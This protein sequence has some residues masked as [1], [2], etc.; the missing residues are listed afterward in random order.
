MT[1]AAAPK[2]AD[3]E[4]RKPEFPATVHAYTDALQLLRDTPGL[5]AD[6]ISDQTGRL[7]WNVKRDLHKLV[8]AGVIEGKGGDHGDKAWSLT[9]KGTRW[10]E[11]ID[12]ASGRAAAATGT[13][14]V[15]EVLLAQLAPDPDQPRKAFDE[16]QL[17]ELA[18]SIA[19]MGLLQPILVRPA[20]PAPGQHTIIAGERRYRAI[21]LLASA[22]RWSADTPVPIR[23]ATPEDEA[24]V[25]E[26]ALVENT[27]R[28]DLNHMEL[29]LGYQRLADLGRTPKQ[30]AAVVGR[31]NDHVTQHLRL[32]RLEAE[33]QAAVAAGTLPL[34]QALEKLRAPKDTPPSLDGRGAGGEGDEPTLADL[35]KPGMVVRTSYNTGPYLVDSVTPHTDDA[36]RAWAIGGRQIENGRP[37]GKSP[38]SWLNGYRLVWDG[39]TPRFL[40]ASG[41]E[42]FIVETS[43]A[44]PVLSDSDP[45]V[46]NGIRYPNTTRA[47]EA[48]YAARLE[49]RKANHSAQAASDRVASDSGKQADPDEPPLP[50]GTEEEASV[51]D[52]PLTTHD[53]LPTLSPRA[54][55]ALIELAHKSGDERRPFEDGWHGAS[56]GS[57]WLDTT[58]SELTAAGL[59]T[60]AQVRGG[61]PPI[62]AL[63]HKGSAWLDSQGFELPVTDAAKEKAQ[64]A[65]GLD[66]HDWPYVTPWLAQVAQPAEAPIDSAQ[67][68][69][70]RV[71]SD[72]AQSDEAAA[73]LDRTVLALVA[74][75]GEVLMAN[76][77]KVFADLG[78]TSVDMFGGDGFEG[79][80]TL[81]GPDNQPVTH[82]TVDIDGEL[83]DSRAK[84]LA[85]LIAHQLSRVLA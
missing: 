67:A 77:A 33:D 17:R 19:A 1:A 55:L 48:R 38:D 85:A 6:Q 32:T 57:Y 63:T 62:A 15:A 75:R 2:V 21:G 4:T 65:S 18:D 49:E 60:F 9:A 58:H 73:D 29:A 20:G 59:A 72:S 53:S 8:D 56:V 35:I 71:A 81:L 61:L 54:R 83:P 42:V 27:Q 30:I 37:R 23:I 74:A 25:M 13:S 24:E 10:V 45:L 47:Q 26:L 7:K 78:I 69:S 36:G 52:S 34:H 43:L 16:E 31:T 80:I 22:G 79:V 14:R 64:I 84:A 40:T 76:P 51:V 41:D 28:T 68:A 11:G 66:I 46:V 50:F 12:V 39:E 5:T 70:D 82:L 44:D 3:R